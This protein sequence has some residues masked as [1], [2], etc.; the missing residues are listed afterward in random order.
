MSK[1]AL[2]IARTIR[3]ISEYVRTVSDTEA[4]D[5]LREINR[6]V[7]T[8]KTRKTILEHKLTEIHYQVYD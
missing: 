5:L 3:G 1:K 4:R 7:G 2:K 6:R 8:V